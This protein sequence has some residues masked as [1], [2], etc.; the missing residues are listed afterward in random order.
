MGF[1]NPSLGSVTLR[2]TS[3]KDITLRLSI[4]KDD[5]QISI[6]SSDDSVL[7]TVII[8][9]DYE[10]SQLVSLIETCYNYM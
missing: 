5:L 6:I 3:G 8:E 7:T 9:D 10:V 2:S 1:N 4:N